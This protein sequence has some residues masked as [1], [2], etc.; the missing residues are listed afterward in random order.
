MNSPVK[1]FNRVEKKYLLSS[2]QKNI[3]YEAIRDMV[4]PDKYHQYTISNIYYDTESFD[5]I[6]RSIDKPIYKE[7]LR[8][9]GYGTPGPDDPVFIEI[10]KK[11]H[12]TVNK[13][14]IILPLE[15]AEN[16]LDYGLLA[17]EY[18]TNQIFKEIDYILNFYNPEPKLYLAYDR[19]AYVGSE[20]NSLRI[21][22]DN[23]IRS[24]TDQL[25]L[26]SG[27]HGDRLLDKDLFLMEIKANTAVPLWLAQTLS[28]Q[29]I[30]PV[31]FSKYGNIYRRKILCSQV[32]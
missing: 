3:F 21:T 5:L 26:S 7:K 27:D 17:E 19:V 24:R 2:H 10:K 4:E 20:D 15:R 1:V 16:Y 29:E 18:K 25:S 31:S 12:G 32:F 13:R 28:K 8:L 23:D 14:R 11:F 6:R 30:Y 22:F 9:R